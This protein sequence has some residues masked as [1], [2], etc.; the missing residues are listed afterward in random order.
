MDIM[1]ITGNLITPCKTIWLDLS[2]SNFTHSCCYYS[3]HKSATKSGNLPLQYWLRFSARRKHELFILIFSMTYAKVYSFP[4]ILHLCVASWSH[5]SH[6]T[7]ATKMIEKRSLKYN[8]IQQR[9]LRKMILFNIINRL[10]MLIQ[11][12]YLMYRITNL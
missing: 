1:V 2:L 10:Q 11:Q 8:S 4:Y 7:S 6:S 12:D 9:Q 5:Y 3:L